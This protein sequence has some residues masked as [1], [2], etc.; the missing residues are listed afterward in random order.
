MIDII[1]GFIVNTLLVRIYFIP[2]VYVIIIFLIKIFGIWKH[3][4]NINNQVKC[5]NCE[6]SVKRISSEALDNLFS[7]LSFRLFR[8]KRYTCF[9]CYWEGRLW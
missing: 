8:F 1:V 2:S 5:P 3:K 4:K 9:T 6:N 7:I